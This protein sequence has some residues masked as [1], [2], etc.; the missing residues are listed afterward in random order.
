MATKPA[1]IMS[2]PL[3]PEF[4]RVVQNAIRQVTVKDLGPITAER[5]LND[6]GLDSVS[7][8]ELIIVLEDS[9][10]LNLDQTEVEKLKNF[11]DLA[12]LVEQAKAKR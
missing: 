10:D 4:I 11:G 12:A 6:L 1:Y 5:E 7:T 8:A 9:F 3:D 2:Q